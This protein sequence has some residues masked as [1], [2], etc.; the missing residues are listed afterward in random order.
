MAE[1]KLCGLAERLREPLEAAVGAQPLGT[2]RAGAPPP[3]SSGRGSR[4]RRS[5]AGSPGARV[6]AMTERSSSASTVSAAPMSA[7]SDSIAS[8]LFAYATAWSR[9]RPPSAARPSSSATS[10][11]EAAPRATPSAARGAASAR[12]ESEPP[13]RN[14]PRRYARRQH[15]RATTRRGGRSSGACRLSRT[16]AAT[17]TSS[18]SLRR[19][20][21]AAGSASPGRTHGG[22][23]SGSPSGSPQSRSSANARRAT[24][25]LATSRCSAQSPPPRRCRLPAE[26]KSAESSASRSQSRSGEIRAS[27]SRTSSDGSQGDAL[28]REQPPLDADAG[29]AVA[30]DPVAPRRRDGRERRT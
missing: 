20:R 30:A 5:R 17:S 12:L 9:A 1:A 13:P 28:E 4:D 29:R 15:A 7:S 24:A 25:P 21:R 3:R 23:T 26:W 8:Q 6:A 10:T 19:P 16:P 2:P 27:S 22:D 14:A 11:R 18:D